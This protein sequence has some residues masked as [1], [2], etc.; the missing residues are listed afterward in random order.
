MPWGAVAAVGGALITS[1]AAGDAADQQ[2]QSADQA[3]MMEM[4]ANQQMREDLSP[5]VESGRGANS[6]LNQYLGVGGAGSGHITSMGLSTGLSPEQV[7]QQLAS[8]F[9]RTVAPAGPKFD[10]NQ[11]APMDRAMYQARIQN[12]DPAERAQWEAQHLGIPGDVR[13]STRDGVQADTQAYGQ[14]GSPTSEIDEAGLNAAMQQYYAEQEAL[15]AQ[16]AQDPKYGSLLRAYRNG[17]EFDSGPAFSFTGADLKNEPGYQFGLNQGTQGIERGQA[18][19]GNFLSGAAMKELTRFN[20]DYAGTKFDAGFNRASATYGTNLARR[21]NEWNT[22][23]GAYNQN[24]NTIYNFLTGVSNTGQASAARVGANNQQVAN[25]VGNN[26]MASGNAQAAGTVA[27][28]NALAS[29][30]NSAVNNYNSS[31]NLNSAAGWNN[32]LSGSGGG[33]SGYTGYVGQSDPIANL[34]TTNGWT[35]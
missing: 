31:N 2:S 1:S 18:A 28:G 15:N 5:W 34:N 21:Q 26:M 20:E 32:M 22:N 19:R 12:G 29:G 3:M 16:A 25:S 7:R 9:T 6:L 27:G 23:L 11:L 14:A 33:Y 24:R 10:V 30:I 13:N 8:R 4:Q 35:S 17:A